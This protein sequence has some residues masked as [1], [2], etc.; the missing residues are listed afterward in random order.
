[1]RSESRSRT[2]G[3]N[4]MLAS[5]LVLG[6]GTASRAFAQSTSGGAVGQDDAHKAWRESLK[7]VPQPGEGCFHATFPN[8]AWNKVQCGEPSGY[9]SVPHKN[10]HV[11]E[12]FDAQGVAHQVTGNGTDYEAQAP[13]GQLITTAA[14]SFPSTSNVTSEQ[15]VGVAA[16]DYGGVTGP[17]QYTLQLNTN[18]YNKSKACSGS[19]CYSWQ[20]Y[21][22]VSDDV[23]ASGTALTGTSDVFIQTWLLN[24]GQDVDGGQTDICPTGF[25]DAGSDSQGPGDDCV[26]NSPAT[27]VAE[28]L[29][30]TALPSLSLS[31]S[32]T[33]NG[34]DTAIVTY[35]DDA[36]SS[37]VDDTVSD[38]AA[39]WTQ[40]EF[41][42]VGNA[43]GSEAVFNTPSGLTVNVALLDGST[44]APTCVGPS[45][46]GTTGET[47][48]FTLGSCN[49]SG[50][51]ST[52]AITSSTP[53][54]QFTESN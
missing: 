33:T 7:Q 31:G 53:S 27:V 10:P 13:V 41:N 26:R 16:Y 51:T 48:N 49:G 54:I 20:Q 45:N 25:E 32:A 39:G 42:V 52:S 47:N 11:A 22:L 19:G 34:T 36:Y 24:Y 9:R 40:A 3:T 12:Q 28:Q 21:I 4:L 43:G 15:G 23:N 29:P 8:L 1:M 30:I 44:A 38:I 18:L 17:N 2:I 46:G 37:S 14:G 35:N 6:C 50:G 5:V